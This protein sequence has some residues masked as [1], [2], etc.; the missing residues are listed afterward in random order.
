MD[1]NQGREGCILKYSKFLHFVATLPNSKLSVYVVD[2][3]ETGLRLTIH[4]MI[5]V[6]R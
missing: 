3:H 5:R 2:G 6:E 1:S 4:D